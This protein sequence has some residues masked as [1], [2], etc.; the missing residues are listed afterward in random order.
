MLWINNVVV[1]TLNLPFL[2]EEAS[3]LL[4]HVPP[5]PFLTS[6]LEHY[7]NMLNNL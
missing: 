6:N 5:D 7:L 2:K 4:V 1:V 3:C